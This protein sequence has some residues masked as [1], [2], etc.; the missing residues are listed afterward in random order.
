MMMP[1]N[2]AL[3]QRR[4]GIDP[5][6]A[7][8]FFSSRRRHTIYWRDWSSDVCSSDLG[9]E[10]GE[11]REVQTAIFRKCQMTPDSVDGDSE[12]FRVEL[13]EFRHQLRIESE[14][15]AADGAPVRGIEAQHHGPAEKISE[16][17]MLIRRRLEGEVRR[18]G[19]GL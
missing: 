18:L 16:R 8:F 2:A 10:V 14:L 13:P 17:Y 12:E 4:Y 6:D 5:I 7:V 11:K 9:V 3:L 1:R 15:V 19:A